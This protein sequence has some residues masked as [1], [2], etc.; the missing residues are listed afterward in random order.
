MKKNKI[1]KLVKICISWNKKEISSDEAVSKI[2][3]LFEDKI[4]P[5]WNKLIKIKSPIFIRCQCSNWWKARDTRY[6]NKAI[7]GKCGN[8]FELI[9]LE[10]IFNDFD[11]M[12]KYPLNRLLK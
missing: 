9:Y 1:K 10:T 4:L 3:N 2:Y 5:E 8:R 12:M 11:Q 7:C 6:S